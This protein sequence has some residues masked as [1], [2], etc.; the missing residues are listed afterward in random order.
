LKNTYFLALGLFK[1]G[2]SDIEIGEG[3]AR[4]PAARPLEKSGG[5][6][7]IRQAILLDISEL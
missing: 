2:E 3:V 6:A 7:I 5:F 4:I 1:F